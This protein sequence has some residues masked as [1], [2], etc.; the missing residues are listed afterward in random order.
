MRA[1]RRWV[2]AICLAAA[3]GGCRSAGND[4]AAPKRGPSR[5]IAGTCELDRGRSFSFSLARVGD[6][7]DVRFDPSDGKFVLTGGNEGVRIF[8]MG[9]V[10]L[11]SIRVAPAAATEAG[12]SVRLLTGHSYVVAL[13]KGEFFAKIQVDR[14][15]HRFYDEAPYVR[16]SYVYQAN[17]SRS[18]AA[19]EAPA[20]PLGNLRAKSRLLQTRIDKGIPTFRQALR[21]QAKEVTA[22]MQAAASE[23][24]KATLRMELR[25]IARL[26]AATE[27]YE[28]QCR[29][30]LVRV[31]SAVRRLE[32]LEAS[33]R[34]L[35][36]D[37]EQALKELWTLEREAGARL[38]VRLGTKLGSGAIEDALVEDQLR[39]LGG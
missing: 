23:S 39:K 27:E 14:T 38:E 1:A 37:D 4:H 29:D 5:L 2:L 22:E 31:G 30:T 3:T 36:L 15:G 10:A 35:G 18:F 8:D 9:P 11:G 25:D 32:R 6:T 7:G 20:L 17:G 21:D 33:E 34:H 13:H 26:L 12:A 16:L 24:V 28:R 19:G